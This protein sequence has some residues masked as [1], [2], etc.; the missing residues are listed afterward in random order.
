MFYKLEKSSDLFQLPFMS[1]LAAT[2]SVLKTRLEEKATLLQGE[3]QVSTAKQCK[4]SNSS[5]R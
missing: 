1:I 2:K 4:Y 3:D 5:L